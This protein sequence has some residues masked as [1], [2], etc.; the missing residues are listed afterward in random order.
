MGLVLGV[1]VDVIEFS[2]LL[3]V[4]AG[5]RMG[6]DVIDKLAAAH[7]PPPVTHRFQIVLSAS[8]HRVSPKVCRFD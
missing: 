8:Q 3:R 5:L 2:D 1:E 6:R 4:A 7:D